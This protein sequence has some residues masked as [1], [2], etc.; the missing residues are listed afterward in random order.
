MPISISNSHITI[1]SLKST[2]SAEN[3]VFA[4]CMKSPVSQEREEYTNRIQCRRSSLLDVHSSAILPS[5]TYT[6]F[7]RQVGGG[8]AFQSITEYVNDE[9]T[10]KAF[11]LPE[12]EL[13]DKRAYERERVKSMIESK[14]LREKQRHEHCMNI[15]TSLDQRTTKK[16]NNYETAN[17]NQLTASLR[18]QR[19]KKVARSIEEGRAE[20]AIHRASLSNSLTKKHCLPVNSHSH[21]SKLPSTLDHPRIGSLEEKYE[22]LRQCEIEKWCLSHGKQPA[23]KLLSHEKQV[24]RKWFQEL[25]ERG[26]GQVTSIELQDALLSSG[27]FKTRE[28][29]T[30]VLA[31]MHRSSY[32][33]GAD[34]EDFL[35]ALFYSNAEMN[36]Q[37]SS[38]K[39]KRLQDM[40]ANPLGFG[41]NTLLTEERRMK[42]LRSIFHKTT[43]RSLALLMF[44]LFRLTNHMLDD[45]S[46]E[47]VKQR[48]LHDRYISALEGV[49]LERQAE[50]H[51]HD[52]RRM[53]HRNQDN[54]RHHP[55]IQNYQYQSCEDAEH[56]NSVNALRQELSR[57][58]DHPPLH[59]P[60]HQLAHPLSEQQSSNRYAIYAPI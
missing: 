21:A 6:R 20:L 23:T 39:L 11:T 46:K 58:R 8:K 49:V 57:L 13:I 32:S 41:M 24:L 15:L 54:R 42:F 16:I 29:V 17:T 60:Q 4:S 35:Q 52:R 27:L 38:N 43:G 30:R 59:Q 28:Q 3:E 37:Y 51:F 40:C 22:D 10:E 19:E 31:N 12:E 7:L 9:F 5:D 36:S 34:F 55:Q 2:Q 50:R 47:A 45:S 44:W 48:K 53:H 26:D 33:D 56:A 25:D 14:H 18:V 1:A